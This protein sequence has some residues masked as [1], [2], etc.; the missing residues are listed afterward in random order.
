MPVQLTSE[1]S[2]HSIFL[3]GGE[4][5]IFPRELLK[6]RGLAQARKNL[7]TSPVEGL[8]IYEKIELRCLQSLLEMQYRNKSMPKRIKD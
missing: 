6:I 2:S 4:T 8:I 1:N 5:S 7:F 3:L